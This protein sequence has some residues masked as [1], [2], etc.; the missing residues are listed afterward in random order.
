MRTHSSPGRVIE[1]DV[2]CA[3]ARHPPAQRGGDK[4]PLIRPPPPQI[5]NTR[6]LGPESKPVG[7]QLPPFASRG[8]ANGAPELGNGGR[9]CVCAGQT[10]SDSSHLYGVHAVTRHF[11]HFSRYCTQKSRQL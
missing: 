4:V 2:S 7:G 8:D 10:L 1:I 5:N 3:V 9:C 11:G 6:N